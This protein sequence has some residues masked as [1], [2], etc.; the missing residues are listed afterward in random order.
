MSL[1]KAVGITAILY[2][3]YN[4][5][6]SFTMSGLFGLLSLFYPIP[7]SAIYLVAGLLLLDGE[8]KKIAALLG[9]SLILLPLYLSNFNISLIFNNITSPIYLVFSIILPILIMYAA[10][11]E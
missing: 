2:F 10:L 3:L 6:L 5:Y 8:H 11:K 7:L 4:A 9:L 1:G